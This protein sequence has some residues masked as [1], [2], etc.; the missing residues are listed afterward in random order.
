MCQFETQGPS[1]DAPSPAFRI[2]GDPPYRVIV[3]RPE[4]SERPSE[5]APGLTALARL[6]AE[7]IQEEASC[8]E[9]GLKML[10]D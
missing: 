3:V 5:A 9:V 10:E 8:E 2:G 4:S 1:H 7:K 6:I